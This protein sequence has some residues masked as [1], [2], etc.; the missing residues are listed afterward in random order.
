MGNTRDRTITNPATPNELQQLCRFPYNTA[1]PRRNDYQHGVS[2][3]S[4]NRKNTIHTMVRGGDH[5]ILIRL[6]LVRNSSKDPF[7]QKRAKKHGCAILQWM[8]HCIEKKLQT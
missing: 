5:I 1:L 3:N 4:R 2:S 6:H 7:Y 8:I